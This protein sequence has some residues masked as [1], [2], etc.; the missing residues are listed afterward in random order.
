MA[1]LLDLKPLESETDQPMETSFVPYGRLLTMLMPSVCGVVVH[2]GFSNLVWA[3]DEW[4]LADEPDIVKDAIANAL[5]DPDEFAGHRAHLDADRAVYS[6]AVRG[7]HIELLGVVS[8]LAASLGHANPRPGRCNTSASWCSPR[9]SACA[10]NWRCAR[11][12]GSRE[13]DL[14]VRERD[15]SLM[16]EMS[17]NQTCH[18]R[19][20]RIRSHPEDRRSSTWAA[21]SRPCGCRTRTSRCR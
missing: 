1:R 3:S 14:G 21:R 5:T 15:L 11:K 4:D 9:S 10:A 18:Q 7:E 20:R 12:L 6:F 13:R 8:L 19:C 2:D 17:S 16:L